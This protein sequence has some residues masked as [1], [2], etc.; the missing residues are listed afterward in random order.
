MRACNRAG[1]ALNEAEAAMAPGRSGLRF[2]LISMLRPIAFGLLIA[3]PL[4]AF[5][6]TPELAPALHPAEAQSPAGAEIPPDAPAHEPP[7]AEEDST[8]DKVRAGVHSATEWAARKVDSWF[9]D[10]PFEQGGSVGGRIGLRTLWRQDEG[11]D[12]TA[13][14]AIRVNPPNLREF[15]YLFIGRD[16]TRDV[17]ADTPDTFTRRELLQPETRED[18]SLFVGLGAQLHDLVALRLGVRSGYKPYAQA[19]LQNLW[20]LTARDQFEFRETLFWTLD[21]RLGSTTAL[22]YGHTF[23]PSLVVRWQGAAT[24]TQDTGYFA[25]SSSIGLFKGFGNGRLLSL[26][27]VTDGQTGAA[28]AVTQYGLR[29]KWEQPV[30]RNWLIGEVNAGYFRPLYTDTNERGRQWAFGAGIL[31]NF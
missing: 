29:A 13:R 25:L 9:G 16:N 27:T 31:M 17:V 23:S 12:W 10:K 8:I 11:T 3:L 2:D 21:D 5:S 24:W 19:R 7:E 1:I 14:F 6:A 26:E 22:F 20:Q 28:A 18:Q 4:V 30:Y 15:G